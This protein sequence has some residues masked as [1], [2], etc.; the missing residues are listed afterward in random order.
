MR[1]RVLDAGALLKFAAGDPWTLTVLTMV[2]R[3]GAPVVIP[4]TA[5][6][7]AL[8]ERPAAGVRLHQLIADYGAQPDDLTEPAARRVARLLTI[9]KAPAEDLPVA[10]AVYAAEARDL[11]VYAGDPDAVRRIG[12]DLTID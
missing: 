12:P 7:A 6:A 5:L 9:A 11:P 4:T 10:H 3:S 8:V 2:L 1:G